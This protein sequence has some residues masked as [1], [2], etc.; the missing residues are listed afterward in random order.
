[1]DFT[2]HDG[3]KIWYK[4]WRA[5]APRAVI[6]I[7]TGLAETADYYEEMAKYLNQAGYSVA[8][9][10]YRQHGRTRAG[11]GD[12]NLF[13]NY[14]RDGAQLCS[15]LRASRPGLPVVLF[16][17]SLGTTVSQ[18]AIYE[19]MA[20]WDGIIYTGPS[21]AVIAPERMAELLAVTDRDILLHGADSVNVMIF[22]LVSS[23]YAL[24]STAALPIIMDGR[25]IV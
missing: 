19:K 10:E 15:M 24:S 3:E 7:M 9:H 18:I 14:A 5:D 13:R 20:Q 12:G 6:Q 22:P 1:M 11:Y 2:S 17:H 25:F 8:L 23:K 16:A 4:I 21:H